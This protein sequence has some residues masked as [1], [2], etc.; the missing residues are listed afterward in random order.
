MKRHLCRCS[1]MLE[2]QKMK[3][4]LKDRLKL[5]SP[6][7]TPSQTSP[8]SQPHTY[9]KQLTTLM[10][11]TVK[12]DIQQMR[13]FFVK[14]H[15]ATQAICKLCYSKILSIS[16]ANN[17]HA[18]FGQ[19]LS[20][21]QHNDNVKLFLK[22][23]LEFP[24]TLLNLPFADY[25]ELIR[26]SAIREGLFAYSLVY[27]TTPIRMATALAEAVRN[28]SVDRN[29]KMART[30]ATAVVKVCLL[31]VALSHMR[32]TFEKAE[33]VAIHFDS[34]TIHS[35]KVLVILAKSY[36]PGKGVEVKV[37]D[38]LSV[39]TETAEDLAKHIMTAVLN[40]G[41]D[42]SKVHSLCSDNAVVNLGGVDH[43]KGK[44]AATKVAAQLGHGLI[45]I[46]CI[47]HIINNGFEKGYSKFKPF[48]DMERIVSSTRN[49]FHQKVKNNE[50][51]KKI[52]A[53]EQIELM[54][55]KTLSFTRWASSY[56]ALNSLFQ[57][58]PVLKPVKEKVKKPKGQM[59]TEELNNF[60]LSDVNYVWTELLMTV[61]KQFHSCSQK[62]QGETISLMEGCAVATELSN[63]CNNTQNTINFLFNTETSLGSN[64][65]RLDAQEQSQVRKGITTLLTTSGAYL[66][67]WLKEFNKYDAFEWV[68]LND[69]VSVEEVEETINLLNS[70][71]I[72][73]DFDRKTLIDDVSHLNEAFL[74]I[75]EF[76]N[77]NLPSP[78]EKWNN[79]FE[80]MDLNS[81]SSPTIQKLVSI[82]LS[83]SPSNSVPEGIFSQMKHFWRDGKSN[84]DFWSV[85]AFVM[86]KFNLCKTF[87][88]T[89]FKQE[90][91]EKDDAL[92]REIRS[93]SKFDKLSK[94]QEYTK[95][96]AFLQKE[97][98]DLYLEFEIICENDET[99]V[100][101]D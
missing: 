73:I 63:F 98:S 58:F 38:L 87:S 91:L 9:D 13:Q 68:L 27:T 95:F 67:M 1:R 18:V 64:F 20:S 25:A 36:F 101:L 30:K 57:N 41:I 42:P 47:G 90:F 5:S 79:V 29:Y 55:L 82:I 17:E 24:F 21:R 85:F 70:K 86:I 40:A 65:A 62:V 14:S 61:T 51:F 53:Q 76:E 37:I 69:V 78:I 6:A 39:I 99:A 45:D 88:V 93:N 31:K 11:A 94:K 8:N 22:N 44:N 23:K 60:Y 49:S 84:I 16:Q 46:G 97:L 32:S 92:L 71:Q 15:D 26:Q 80:T 72:K 48:F 2:V 96:S 3:I 83:L 34:T 50:T 66:K 75:Y 35:K 52:A 77:K 19:H 28:S 59:S 74:E 4:D 56:N 81:T 54:K 33:S 7:S 10:E 43:K 89:D 12:L 100:Y